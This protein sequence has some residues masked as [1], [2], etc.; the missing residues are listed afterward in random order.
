LLLGSSGKDRASKVL[1]PVKNGNVC[2]HGS[3]CLPTTP[4]DTSVGYRGSSGPVGDASALRTPQ[5]T[6]R[7]AV[8]AS[9]V[10]ILARSTLPTFDHRP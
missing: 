8:V 5:L 4:P 1:V 2:I 9:L 3:P 10:S 7:T 6:A